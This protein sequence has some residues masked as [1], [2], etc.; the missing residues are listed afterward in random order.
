MVKKRGRPAKKEVPL[1]KTYVIEKANAEDNK[2]NTEEA[3]RSAD[4]DNKAGGSKDVGRRAD[5]AEKR[6]T[7]K[8]V[9]D[10]EPPKK[11]A[12]RLPIDIPKRVTRSQTAAQRARDQAQKK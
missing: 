10:G 1:D 12:R 11:V 3:E 2:E 5:V 7:A 9:E 6:K 8:P 4:D